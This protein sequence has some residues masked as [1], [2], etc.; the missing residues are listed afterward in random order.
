MA[1]SSL[2][3]IYFNYDQWVGH[4]V[5]QAVTTQYVESQGGVISHVGCPIGKTQKVLKGERVC[6]EYPTLVACG[7]VVL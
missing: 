1:Y 7:V 3:Y 5:R 2:I 6:F 4:L